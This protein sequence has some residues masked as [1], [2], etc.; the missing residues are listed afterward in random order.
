[1]AAAAVVAWK[2]VIKH[3]QQLTADPKNEDAV[4]SATSELLSLCDD[5]SS[6]ALPP[7]TVRKL[8]NEL[9]VTHLAN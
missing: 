3:L 5:I 6:D 7:A 4:S 1:M 9:K 8:V 2:S